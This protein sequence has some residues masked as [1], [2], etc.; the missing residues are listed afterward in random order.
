MCEMIDDAPRC[1]CLAGYEVRA[2]E[3]TCRGE[4]SRTILCKNKMQYAYF[5]SEYL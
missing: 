2:D 4:F 3:H 1:L 5:V